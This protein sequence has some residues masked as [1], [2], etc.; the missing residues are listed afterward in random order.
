MCGVYTL[1]LG[2]PLG[3]GFKNIYKIL[4]GCVIYGCY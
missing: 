4:E 2:V 3:H 1:I